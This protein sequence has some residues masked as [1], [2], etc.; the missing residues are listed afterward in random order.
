MDKYTYKCST[1]SKIY[2]FSHPQSYKNCKACEE[3]G[4]LRLQSILHDDVEENDKDDEPEMPEGGWE[5]SECGAPVN[6]MNDVCS[7]SCFN[8]MMR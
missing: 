8:A 5:C 3:R 1:C 2:N 7:Q 4:E 6:N